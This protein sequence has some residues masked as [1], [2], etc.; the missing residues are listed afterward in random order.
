MWFS[1]QVPGGIS[2]DLQPP[3]TEQEVADVARTL[4]GAWRDATSGRDAVLF[5]RE[6]WTVL[7]RA[8][9]LDGGLPSLAGGAGFGLFEQCVVLA[10]VGRFGAPVPYASSIAVA[11]AIVA[12]FGTLDQI[13]R[14]ALPVWQADATFGVVD[15]AGVSVR[16]GRLY[17]TNKAVAAGA[18]ADFL[19]VI[20]QDGV[21]LTCRSEFAVVMAR[22]RTTGGI[23]SAPV[24]FDGADAERLAGQEAVARAGARAA[25][26]SCAWRL[27]AMEKALST[28]AAHPRV[29]VGESIT[30]AAEMRALVNR[31][32]I[33]ADELRT[34]LR[35]AAVCPPGDPNAERQLEAARHR[36]M[37]AAQAI[38]YAARLPDDDDVDS[39]DFPLR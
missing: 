9:L 3:E 10:E 12:E 8:G 14:W 17:G 37:L 4:L 18:F 35:Q 27:G 6:L 23:S 34:A 33:G 31:I 1:R 24:E 25:L 28:V 15:G 39:E 16:G 22:S 7:A 36:A 32:R 21:Y 26:A 38:R 11:T 29:Q 5:D 20:T 30:D 13:E 2:V 19:L